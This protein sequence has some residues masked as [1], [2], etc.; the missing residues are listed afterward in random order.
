MDDHL[1]HGGALPLMCQFNNAAGLE[2]L[3]GQGARAVVLV[4]HELQRLDDLGV[5]AETEEVLWR[6]AQADDG[7]AQ[8]R[9]DEH[10]GAAGEEDVPPSPVA[11]LGARLSVE[12]VPLLRDHEPPGNEAGNS[13]AD[14]PPGR[15]QG[16]QP[17]LVAGEEL[18]EDGGVQDEVAAAAEAEEGDEEAEGGP[19]RHGAGD[20]AARGADEEGDVEGVLAADDVGAEAPEYG[21]GEHAGV[22]GDGEA[23]CVA[24][25]AE[26]LVGLV[27]DDG[28]EE[29]D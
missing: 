3:E 17:L 5:L 6:L 10:E 16:Q 8:D 29:E 28:L 19:V 27:G 12:T 15:Q 11:V 20:Y 18:E 2:L 13:L 7:D 22:G 4:G 26:L 21:A 25:G 14:T 1:T 23:V 9:Q 24:A